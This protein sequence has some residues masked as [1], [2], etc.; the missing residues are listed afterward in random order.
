LGTIIE[1]DLCLSPIRGLSDLERRE[2]GLEECRCEGWS[3]SEELE[4]AEDEA[5]I[6]GETLRRTSENPWF[7]VVTELG[8]GYGLVAMVDVDC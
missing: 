4:A 1:D 6:V 5:D 2:D 3:E 7:V 8:S